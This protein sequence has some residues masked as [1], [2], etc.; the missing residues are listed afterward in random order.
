MH[1]IHL[2]DFLHNGKWL[3]KINHTPCEPAGESRAKV[4]FSHAIYSASFVLFTLFWHNYC[5]FG[6][7][8]RQ[9][10]S[11]SPGYSF[12]F[13][14]LFIPFGTNC[15]EWLMSHS[16]MPMQNARNKEISANANAH[17][18][19]TN[20]THPHVAISVCSLLF[21][22]LISRPQGLSS[23]SQ[24]T[25]DQQTVIETKSERPESIAN[26]NDNHKDCVATFGGTASMGQSL[27]VP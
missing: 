10:G 17:L 6:P 14:H 26:W 23:G 21:C 7:S 20:Y 1:L 16:L 27:R 18:N 3:W 8:S 24:P 4:R 19:Y 15:R 2:R 22:Q 5:L 9:S 25:T 11:Q 12:A 13:A